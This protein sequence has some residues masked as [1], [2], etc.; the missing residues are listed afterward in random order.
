MHSLPPRLISVYRWL[1]NDPFSCSS[2]SVIV[3]HRFLN[4][5]PNQPVLSDTRLSCICMKLCFHSSVVWFG[6]SHLG[7]DC[8][9]SAGYEDRCS[10]SAAVQH[11]NKLIVKEHNTQDEN[12][13]VCRPLCA[14]AVLSPFLKVGWCVSLIIE[15]QTLAG[16]LAHAL[17][18]PECTHRTA[19]NPVN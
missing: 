10:G 1:Q 14:A 18:R 12:L 15:A 6:T 3:H 7:L 17:F 8:V 2:F 13:S 5:S 9:S 16:W 19:A 11:R 4:S